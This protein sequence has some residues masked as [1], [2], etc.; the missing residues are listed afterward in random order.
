MQAM[1]YHL[2]T[3][4]PQEAA[5]Y[6]MKY[7]E[8]FYRYPPEAE[9][10]INTEQQKYDF[11]FCGEQKDRGRRLADLEQLQGQQQQLIELKDSELATVQQRLAESNEQFIARVSRLAR[12]VGKEVATPDDAREILGLRK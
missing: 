4:D 8:Q 6:G 9:G 3:F 10:S 7:A 12:E 5:K 2:V 1:G 11:F